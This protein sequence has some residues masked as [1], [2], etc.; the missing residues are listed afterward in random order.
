[1]ALVRGLP[2][3]DMAPAVL[4]RPGDRRPLVLRGRARQVEVRPV[5]AGLRLL[6]GQK[7][8]PEP[9]PV[10]RQ[11]HHV[12]ARPPA[13]RQRSTSDQKRA[14]SDGRGERKQIANS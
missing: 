14:D 10:G 8:D 13:G 9:G 2:H 5:L 7:T 4:Q 6:T 1:M 12:L 11:E 3:V